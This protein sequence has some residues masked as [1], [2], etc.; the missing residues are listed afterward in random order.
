LVVD[1]VIE[2]D[3]TRLP[4][5]AKPG[6]P[7]PGA[8]RAVHG[9]PEECGIRKACGHNIARGDLNAF[10]AYR[11]NLVQPQLVQGL[12]HTD[13]ALRFSVWMISPRTRSSR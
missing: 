4:V 6:H 13:Y 8:G 11:I 9:V 2:V 1:D 12:E 5:F 10:H 3:L 7:Q